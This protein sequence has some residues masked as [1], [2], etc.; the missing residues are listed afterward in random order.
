MIEQPFFIVGA[1]RSGTTLLR[2]ML[3]HHR[4]LACHF[5]FE[6][7]VEMVGDDGSFPP[8]E[9][10]RQWL[11]AQ[12][13][14]SGSGVTIDQSLD[15]LRLVDSFLVQKRVSEGKQIV[16]GTVHKHFDRLQHLWPDARFIHIIR[17]GRDVA[18]SCVAM[19]WAG[20]SWGGADRWITAETLWDELRCKLSTSD[21]CEIRYEDLI[22]EPRKVL[23]EICD[24]IGVEFDGGMFDYAETSTYDLPDP[25]LVYQWKVKASE[26]ETRIM[27]ARIGEMLVRRG[28]ELSGLPELSIEEK[29]VHRLER[30]NRRGRRRFRIKR[31][32]FMLLAMENLSRRLPFRPLHS[33]LSQRMAEI[34]LQYVR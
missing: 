1:E 8:I 25:K 6:H 29:L 17:D 20:N 33:R 9:A 13:S 23:A 4:L 30:E 3:D 31:Y 32:G 28:Y 7:A 15:F 27:E 11:P 34:D 21:Y 10:Y 19:G 26:E 18:R 5:E 12:R 22:R 24:F 16:G 14:F 2:L